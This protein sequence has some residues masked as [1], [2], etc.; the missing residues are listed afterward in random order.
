MW[1]IYA[2]EYYSA[3]KRNEI[4]SFAEMWLNLETL[5]QSEVTF[6]WVNRISLGQ[7]RQPSF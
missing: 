4:V 1:Y 2:T 5:I 3:V 6:N 7:E